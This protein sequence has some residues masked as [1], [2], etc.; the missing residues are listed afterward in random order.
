M[1]QGMAL[2][3]DERRKQFEDG[4]AI[5]EELD[6][7]IPMIRSGLE[8]LVQTPDRPRNLDVAMQNL[9]PGFE[10]LLKL[11]YILAAAHLQGGRPDWRV[12]KGHSHD[13]CG[14]LDSLVDLVAEA[15]GYSTR[16]AVVAD[17]EFMRSDEGL[18]ALLEV[19][20]HFGQ[21]GRYRRIDDLVKD[22]RVGA[23]GEPSR[24]WEEIEQELVWVRPDV[25]DIVDSMDLLTPATFATTAVLQR[26]ARAITRMWTFGT[27]GE[28]NTIHYGVLSVFGRL[29][30]DDLGQQLPAVL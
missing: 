22:Q 10:R 27:L 20:S 17:I 23:D 1:H 19:L 5:I 4:A 29:D 15:E 9:A 30:D 12:L 8:S 7:A 13:L 28:E 18:R 3:P 11:T 14:L 25:D 16:P 6:A 2:T 24:R 21:Y 26:L